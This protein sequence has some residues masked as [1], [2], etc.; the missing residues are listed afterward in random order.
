MDCTH[1]HCHAHT[2]I[3]HDE[4]DPQQDQDQ[5]SIC[6]EKIGCKN[7]ATMKCGHK[8]HFNCIL[9]W[10]FS[11]GG[12]RCPLCR[13]DI[14]LPL[15]QKDGDAENTPLTTPTEITIPGGEIL[16][17][18]YSSTTAV[19]D[20]LDRQIRAVERIRRN[21]QE[22]GT[23]YQ[24]KCSKCNHSLHLCNF[25]TR[26]FCA[27]TNTHGKA[28]NPVNPFNKFYNTLFSTSERD[29]EMIQI[30]GITNP[31]DEDLEAPTVCGSCFS[32]RV[33][34]LTRTMVTLSNGSKFNQSLFNCTEIKMIYYNLF[35]DNSGLTNVGIKR[36]MPSYDSYHI[37]KQYV[38]KKF[39]F[40]Y[41]SIETEA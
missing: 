14:G 25:C 7:V 22:H 5:C 9:Q 40:N 31:H 16:I 20:A 29:D 15:P 2:R 27:C 19:N 3:N 12:N 10:N 26:A 33:G 37:F 34:V 24:I 30:M 41:T 1:T 35:F 18:D 28:H 13:T 32:N 8:F 11:D 21:N 39:G 17:E 38:S 36:L 6:L 23:N 4:N